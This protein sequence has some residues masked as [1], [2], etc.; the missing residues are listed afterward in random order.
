MMAI[1]NCWEYGVQIQE[2]GLKG[3]RYIV[4]DDHKGL[5]KSVKRHFQG[6]VWQR[7]QVHFIRNV[8]SL[9]AKKDRKEILSYLH[10]ITDSRSVE[11]ARKRISETVDR[12]ETSH[13][14]VAVFLD[15]Y[16]EEIL[17]VYSLPESHRKRMRS[18]NMLERYN[19]EIKRRTRVVRIFPNEQ[20]CV[21]LITALAIETNEEWMARRYLT[22]DKDNEKEVSKST[23]DIIAA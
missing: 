23:T 13:P 22:M 4:S 21:R 3:V 12:L 9:V 17:A 10:E 15:T 7:C 20:S 14:K 11:T 19:Q 1:E 5:V 16:G 8:I 18:T 2:R 6:V